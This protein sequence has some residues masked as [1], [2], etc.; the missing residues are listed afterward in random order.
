MTRRTYTLIVGILLLVGLGVAATRLPTQYAAMGPGVTF[1][2]LG[3]NQNGTPIITITG[4]QTH[5]TTGNLNM[6]TVSEYDKMDLLSAIRGWLSASQAV[7]PREELFPPNKTSQQIQQ[8]NKEQFV[9]SQNSATTAALAYLGYGHVYIGSINDG[10]SA[11]GVLKPGDQLVALNGVKVTT[12]PEVMAVMTKVKPGATIPV[13]YKR[14]G[15]TATAN[16]KTGPVQGREGAAIGVEITIDT[17]A[18]FQVKIDLPDIGGPSAGLMFA[19]GILDMLGPENLTG[20]KFI[21]GTGTIDA[22]GNVGP[23][24]GIPLK[25]LGA[26]RAGATVF[27]SPAANCAEAK[28]HKPGGLQLIKVTTLNDAVQALD[29]LRSG[30]TPP[31]C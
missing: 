3:N 18:P 13:E 11:Q 27:L 26:V 28:A 31:T 2:T 5:Q 23:I 6:T 7:V 9:S 16:L 17:D 12:Q 29:T 14:D 21:A 24:G 4:E 10:S 19:L 8:E 1:N 20:G 22:F 25:M 15:K 30:G